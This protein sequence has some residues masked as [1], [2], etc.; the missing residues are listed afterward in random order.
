MG[1]EVLVGGLWGAVL[2]YWLWT[3]RPASDTVGA[4]H[5]ELQVLQRA[6]PARVAPANRLLPPHMPEEHLATPFEPS[7]RR[8]ARQPASGVLPPQV[9]AVAAINKRSEL[10][11]RR[12]DVLTLLAVVATVT[13]FA[14]VLSGS[15]V[16]IA[17][18]VSSDLALAAYMYLLSWAG[19]ARGATAYVPRSRLYRPPAPSMGYELHAPAR[20]QVRARARTRAPA[21]ASASLYGD[22]DSY[23][24]LA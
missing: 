7:A 3:R 17:F 23:A 12:R 14:A 15:T 11:R 4:F 24:S 6:T 18:Q 21:G 2:A 13:L 22:F 20:R 1:L 8:G 10:R 9:A 5:R 16:A 19:R